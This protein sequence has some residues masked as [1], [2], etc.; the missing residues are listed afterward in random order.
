MKAL[1]MIQ[2]TMI[3]KEIPDSQFLSSHHCEHRA[4]QTEKKSYSVKN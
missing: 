4:T 1:K 2:L 3:N